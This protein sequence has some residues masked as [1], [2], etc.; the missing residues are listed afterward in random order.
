[1]ARA[2]DSNDISVR[3]W[4]FAPVVRW[5]TGGQGRPAA[6]ALVVLL[7]LFYIALGERAW[8]PI[9]NLLFDAYQRVMPRQISR[10]PVVI[11]DID[12]ASLAALG[13]WPWPRTRLARLID[14]THRSGALAV[15][16]DII[17][18]EADSLSPGG[19]LVDRQDVSPGLQDAL[20][21]LPSNDTIL[22]Q[23]LRRIPTV[24]GRA[25]IADGEAQSKPEHG[26]T[27]VVI[28]GEK[29]VGGGLQSYARHLTNLPEIE[30]AAPGHGYLNDTRDTD[31]VVR[32]MPLLIAVNGAIAPS[33]GFE[34]LRVAT[35]QAQ[36][37]VQSS[38]NGINGV[39]IGTSFIPTDPDGRIR[40]HFSPADGARRVSAEAVLRG[41]VA[42]NAFANQVAIIGSTALGVTDV[43][44][45]PI[46][47]RMVGA[48]IQAQLVENILAGT[49]LKRP[50]IISWL[51]L[52]TFLS[53]AIA[54]I[55]LLPRMGPGYG[56]AIFLAGALI[57]G[58]VS[59]ICFFQSKLL[60]DPSFATAGNLLLLMVLLTAGFS[61]ANRHRRELD[62]ALAAERIERSRMA[63]EL[64]AARKIQMGMLPVPG[65]I[66]GLP[67]AIEFYATLEPALEVGGD[68]YDA[69]MLDEEHFFFLVG[70]VS[71]K[72][73]PASLFMALSKT[74][75]KSLALREHVPL[76][77][78][79]RLVNEEISRENPASLFVSAVVGIINVRTGVLEFC[80]AG[81][82]API[83]LRANQP[84]RSLHSVGGPPLCVDEDFPYAIDRIQLQKDDLLVTI[85]DG[86]TEAQDASQNFYGMERVLAYFSTM[87]ERQLSSAEAVC[88]GLDAD[89][90]R[91]MDGVALSDDITIMAIRLAG[92]PSA[93]P[94]V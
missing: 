74:L 73:V 58:I 56:V 6:I 52:L 19:L 20:A 63:G 40:L 91:F 28:I 33:F 86:V 66:E 55:V 13:R 23:T 8:S 78:L 25:A 12:D 29:P 68:L 24:I 11:V 67:A 16:L 81:H 36:Y 71:G 26:Q 93:A 14:A 89:V 57:V 64:Q 30:A 82:E 84:P 54:L 32:S 43:A 2:A 7:S 39:Q 87:E 5:F 41:A 42:P 46:A 75:C 21:K 47:T 65:A 94:P 50:P 15:G 62:A 76:D 44:A 79:L 48:E 85:T 45:T 72:G 38:R 90:R 53:M 88:A 59:I 37:T 80:N 9:R 51:E 17:M 35:G 69:F 4:S 49:R 61:A 92:L 10:Y 31:G 77:A 3:R 1:V 60:Y 83:L 70:D 18:P 22:A 34:L 27:P